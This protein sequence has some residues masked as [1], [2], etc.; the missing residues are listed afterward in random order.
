VLDALRVQ[1]L[2][3]A[4]WELLLIDNA[5]NDALAESVDLSWHPAGRHVR[6]DELGLTPARLR[7]IS[8]SRGPIIVFVDDDNVLE[9]DFL[10]EAVRIGKA[11]PFLGAW[12]GNIELKFEVRPPEWVQ[13]YRAHLAYRC[14]DV[15]R[16]SNIKTDIQS[17]PYGAGMCVRSAVCGAYARTL[18]DDSLRRSLDRR[19]ASLLAGGDIDLVLSASD[20]SLGW[21]NF[22]SL[23]TT[24]L[25]PP[26]R[27]ELA[28]MLRLREEVTM[29]NTILA[30]L[31]GHFRT[32]DPWWRYSIQWV[33]RRIRCGRYEAMFMAAERRGRLRAIS[34]AQA[35]V[36]S[37]PVSETR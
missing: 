10:A 17:Q 36:K 12:G 33:W 18:K 27:T 19:G 8:E 13:R 25:I 6:E 15:P 7:G 11:Y 34:P 20:L 1:T 14:F 28:Y 31:H 5:S 26:Q 37:E 29:S 16:W 32:P 21:G 35:Y 3:F 24:H 2:P 22:P 9:S 4:K 23:T 30:K